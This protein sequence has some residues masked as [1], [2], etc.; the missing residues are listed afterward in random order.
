VDVPGFD[1]ALNFRS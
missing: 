1:F